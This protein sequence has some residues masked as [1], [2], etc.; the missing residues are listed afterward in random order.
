MPPTAFSPV[1]SWQRVFSQVELG[2]AVRV[3]LV[4]FLTTL[5]AVAAAR[6]SAGVGAA[7][8][9]AL[10]NG[11]IRSD[12][13]DKVQTKDSEEL[14][15]SIKDEATAE[16]AKLGDTYKAAAKKVEEYI[17]A[18]VEWTDWHMKQGE[19]KEV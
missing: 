19:L 9:K 5:A 13:G 14:A 6:K 3:F 2:A 10:K 17:N 12:T 4:H 8:E 16:T 1:V 7:K 11:N 18:G 15:E